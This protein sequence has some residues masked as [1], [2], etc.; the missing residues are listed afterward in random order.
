MNPLQMI[1]KLRQARNPMDLMTQMFNKNP[2][3]TRVMEIAKGKTPQELEAY[4]RNVAQTQGIDINQ[5]LN[6]FGFNTNK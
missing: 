4:A 1:A 5:I 3:F 2:Q 6:Q